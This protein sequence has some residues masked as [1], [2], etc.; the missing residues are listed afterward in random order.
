MARLRHSD[1]VIFIE[2]EIVIDSVS[3]LLSSIEGAFSKFRR[4]EMTVDL[5]EV[6]RVDSAGV[7]LLDEVLERARAKNISIQ[8]LNVPEMVAQTLVAF[9]TKGLDER[10]STASLSIFEKIGGAT[11]QIVKDLLEARLRG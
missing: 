8:F 2:G 4:S 7:A 9:S 3:H 10:T 1:D 11:H 6:T 5:S